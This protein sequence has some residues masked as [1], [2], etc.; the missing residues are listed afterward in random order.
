[1]TPSPARCWTRSPPSRSPWRWPPP[2]RSPAGASGSAGPPSSPSSGPATTLTAPSA[3]SAPVEPENRLV[4]R[5]PGGPLGSQARRLAEAEQALEA[6][7]GRAAAAARPGRAGETRRRP[8]RALAR[9]DHQRQGPQAAA[10]HPDRR[11]H[12]AARARPEPRSR[13]GIRWHTGA[14]DELAVGPRRSIPAPPG[15]ARP[16]AVE[17]VRGSARRT[18]PHELADAAQRRRA[19]HR[20][21]PAVRRRAPS[22]GSATPTSI[23][24][25]DPYADGE[26]SRRRG[27]QPAGLQHRRHLLLDQDR[28]AHRPPRRRA[29]GSA[30]P[31]TPRSGPLPGTDRPVRPPGPR[32]PPPHTPAP[33]SP[34]A[35]GEISVT[36]TACRLQHQVIT[37]G[38]TPAAHARRRPGTGCTSPGTNRSKPNAAPGR[39]IGQ[40]NPPPDD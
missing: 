29:T 24:A 30:S 8:A 39:A 11:R 36:E 4:A 23:P 35:N 5:S 1:M 14:T 3:R 27:R 16:P 13:I 2:T 10:A 18:A 32:R 33:P 22:S 17:M 20:E 38:S 37:T 6:A 19:D 15:A 40:L 21:R 9:P 28:A 34:A 7:A 26:I 25:P 12:P 31:G